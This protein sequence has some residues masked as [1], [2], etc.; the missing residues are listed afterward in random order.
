MDNDTT[1]RLSIILTLNLV[2][3]SYLEDL[4]CGT[5]PSSKTGEYD[6]VKVITPY[7]EI[8]WNKLSRI[9][10]AEMKILMKDITKKVYNFLNQI[11][12]DDNNSQEKIDRIYRKLEFAATTALNT[13]DDPSL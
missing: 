6:D 13:W 8:P 1:K 9:S 12:D 3:N 7:G 11:S 10:D 4:H 2:R 5:T